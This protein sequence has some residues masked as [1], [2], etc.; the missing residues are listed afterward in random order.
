MSA[1][2]VR[3]SPLALR[4][5]LLLALA[6]PPGLTGCASAPAPLNG[7]GVVQAVAEGRQAGST[8]G[9]LGAIGGAVVGAWLGSGVG[10]GTG[11]AIATTTGSVV[12]SMAAGSA[13]ARAT[14]RL[15]WR[16]TIR[17]DDGID[18]SIVMDDKPDIRPGDR[19]V[20]S[21]GRLSLAR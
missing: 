7:N 19:V 14:T 16:V 5:T 9:V 11:Q 18:R 2:G 17:F 10:G 15:V 6:L 4:V 13:L 12:G 21:D 20:V 3:R 8:G 1:L